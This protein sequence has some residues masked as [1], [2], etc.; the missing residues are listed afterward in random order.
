M[1]LEVEAHLV[2][3]KHLKLRIVDG[4]LLSG[5]LMVYECDEPYLLILTLTT[6]SRS[7]LAKGE[8]GIIRLD[9]F[10]ED[11]S[12]ELKQWLAGR[13]IH[14]PAALVPVRV[15]E[16]MMKF[17][18][19]AT[20]PKQ[21]D[22][23][24]W[25]LSRSELH[26]VGVDNYE[27]IFGGKDLN[28]QEEEEEMMM[29]KAIGNKFNKTASIA[30]ERASQ[31]DS[32][33]QAIPQGQKKTTTTSATSALTP[34]QQQQQ[35]LRV[36]EFT[37]PLEASN[38]DKNKKNSHQSNTNNNTSNRSQ[39]A[40]RMRS[41]SYQP[42]HSWHGMFEITH[43]LLGKSQTLSAIKNEKHM[44]GRD[45]AKKTLTGSQLLSS[46]TYQL[47]NEI[48]R[49]RKD[50]VEKMDERRRMIEIAKIRQ[51][52]SSEK[53]RQ[54]AEESHNK[55]ERESFLRNARQE[56]L[57]L[58]T[59]EDEIKDDILK[60]KTRIHRGNQKVIWTKAPNGFQ[61][62]RGKSHKGPLLGPG[63][64]PPNATSALKDPLI[65]RT[66]QQYY[67]DEA[68]RRHSKQSTQLIQ[69]NDE[70][71]IVTI[72]MEAIRKAAANISA[73]KLDLKAVFEEF[74]RSGDGLLSPMEMAQ[75]FL[76]LGVKLDLPSIDI[77]FKHFDPNGSGSVHYGEFVWAFFNRRNLLRQ[78]KRQT[79]GLTKKQILSHFHRADVNGNGRLNEKEFI[80]L[81]K[82]FHVTLPIKDV[83][84]LMNRFDLDGDGEI[85][86]QEFYGFIQE[87]MANYQGGKGSGGG[88]LSPSTSPLSTRGRSLEDVG[89]QQRDDSL[90]A[91][92]RP[93]SSNQQRMGLNTNGSHA[94][95]KTTMTMNRQDNNDYDETEDEI[96][97]RE[98]AKRK[99]RVMRK[100]V[101]SSSSSPDP[102]SSTSPTAMGDLEEQR[103]APVQETAPSRKQLIA[104]TAKN[105]DD[106]GGDDVLWMSRML[107]A[108]AEIESRLGRRYFRTKTR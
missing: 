9:I 92:H 103:V 93:S 79:Q 57:T 94:I 66:I 87:E 105:E 59:I 44:K 35:S 52:Q 77:I 62:L 17:I 37:F 47:V 11:L 108:Q 46:D 38:S 88:G 32:H 41:E 19:F 16:A 82:A 14:H 24:M 43:R 7:L 18:K 107:Q 86:L 91:K 58:K 63:P 67:W 51:L 26:K 81:L 68:G 25:I 78:W 10:K 49:T 60:Q 31:D 45:D 98:M 100:E 101:L 5:T 55:Q 27:L 34:R 20:T 72:A 73:F 30:A 75:A 54:I 33:Y 99:P 3:T 102:H 12:R 71:S 15:D 104:T 40:N 84:I 53:Y 2:L 6:D 64:L 80:R 29:E 39:S 56:L 42:N 96:I 95:P 85:D 83:Q 76:S 97:A 106:A 36:S 4:S 1:E 65:E 21:A 48:E 23:I 74:D 69:D 8:D 28:G 50:I 61:S 22:L 90:S 89:P 70:E 13:Y